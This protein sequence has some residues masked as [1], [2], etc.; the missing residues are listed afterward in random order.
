MNTYGNCVIIRHSDGTRA[1]YGH[2]KYGS[3]KVKEGQT[4]KQGQVV[5]QI[6]DSGLSTGPHLHF[7]LR[8]KNNKAFNNNKD[9][10]SKG[11]KYIYTV[12]ASAK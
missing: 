7:E 10:S 8:N 12:P 5:G 9:F 6:G 3:I 4:V 1:I 2:L 11:I